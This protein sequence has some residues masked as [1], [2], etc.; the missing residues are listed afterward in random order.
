MF[1]YIDKLRNSEKFKKITSVSILVLLIAYIFTIPSFSNRSTYNLIT[2]GVMILFAFAT[3]VFC[4]LYRGFKLHPAV[5]LLPCFAIFAFI[6]T[7][8]YSQ[9]YRGWFSLILLSISLILFIYSFSALKSRISVLKAISIGLFLFTI[10]FGVIYRRELIDF[11]NFGKENFRLG[12]IFDNPNGIASYMVILFGA[13][14]SVVLFSTKKI[15][16]L[17]LAATLSSCVVG[18]STGSKTFILAVFIFTVV[19]LYFKFIK[20]KLIYVLILVG[21]LVLFGILISLPF[22]Q[23]IRDRF[24]QF[25]ETLLGTAEKADTSTLSR[26]MW[27]KYGFYLG[28]KNIITGYGYGGFGIYSGVA[29]YTHSNISE[30]YCNFG[31]IGTLLFYSPLIVCLVK[32]IIEKRINLSLVIPFFIYYVLVSFSNVFYYN[33]TYYIMIALITYCCFEEEKVRS[34]YKTKKELKKVIF[35][36]DSMNSGGAE[37]VLSILSNNMVENGLDVTIL[38]ISNHE[39]SSFY[40]IDERVKLKCLCG[41][42][43]KKINTFK[44]LSLLR[45]YFKNEQPSVVVSF[46]PHVSIYTH[47]ALLGLDIHHIV[48]ERS[49][50]RFNPKN[51]LIRILKRLVYWHADGLVFQSNDALKYFGN[52]AEFKGKIINNPIYFSNIEKTNYDKS[53]STLISVGRFTEEKN[54]NLL[55]EGFKKAV[56]QRKDLILKIYGDGPLKENIISKIESLNLNNNVV[57]CGLD[58][59]WLQK[60]IDDTG[61]ILSSNYEGMPNA[62][63]E[64]LI[65]GLP[66]I[67][68]N[69]GGVVSDLVCDGKNGYMFECNDSDGLCSKILMLVQNANNDL[70]CNQNKK[71]KG[72]YDEKVVCELWQQYFQN[73]INNNYETK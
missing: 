32:S 61:F 33:K 23:T 55:L 66:C 54:H 58:L 3:I 1:K 11:R 7:A 57:L 28:G 62:L 14:F 46:L 47:Y 36:C 13:S 38:M 60:S 30:V 40:K 39:A 68:T 48:S 9:N 37:R 17:F 19:L 41:S 10:Y 18:V 63:I 34:V 42:S 69:C 8:R 12:E 27:M 31:I 50:P 5:F 56:E 6:G 52:R 73:V 26:F 2:Y 20:H 44:R 65:A 53:N 16:W 64:A 21:V 4:F 25:F 71:L 70:L 45:N 67:V 51:K 59:D 72:N 15:D 24:V 29:A 35:T 49:D 22:M 43:P